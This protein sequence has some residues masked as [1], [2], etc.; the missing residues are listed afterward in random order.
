MKNMAGAP[1]LVAA[2]FLAL[3]FC[4]AALRTDA[5]THVAQVAPT[6][7]RDFGSPPSGRYPIL[8]NNHTVYARPDILKRNR[9]LAALVRDG[10]IYVPLRSMFEQMGAVV[11]ASAD[12]R[13]ITAV[14]PG[15]SVSVTL[16][17]RLV[18]INGESRPLDVP[19]ML[20]KGV[21]LV[22]VRVLSE[23]LGAYVKWVPRRHIVVVRY[24]PATPIATPTP[25][26][27]V[28]P[29]A[30]PT[31]VP[32]AVPIVIP[33]RTYRGFIEAAVAKGNDYNEFS[34][35]QYCRSYLASGA[36][37]FEH[38]KFAVKFGYRYDT[39]VTSDNLTDAYGNHYTQFATID[40]GSA[41]TPVFLA[42]QSTLDARL[43]YQVAAPR[44]YV[45]VGYLRATNNYGY[46]TLNGL[47]VGVEKLPDLRRG[48]NFFG[49]AFYY[50]NASGNYTVTSSTSP[51][52]GKVYRQQYR[53]LQYNVGL[54]LVFAHSPV[55]IYGGFS[56]DRYGAEQNAPIGQT[57]G[58]PYIGL[59]LKF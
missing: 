33:L 18:V 12:G 50:P 34:A 19:P 16:G 57:H 10:R 48:I 39:Y 44:V 27:T 17:K 7:A 4:G 32:T 20:Y 23:A 41:F 52:A 22:P 54:D 30:A 2:S 28:A 8:Y 59:G 45:G 47:G 46:P 26:P 1:R 5:A 15:V 9:V 40:G 29:T 24:I 49:S 37:M 56:G 11:T 51:N 53:I 21:M 6:P 25:M 38:S 55:Y 3:A 42:R 13:T 43:E 35:G 14:K 36:Y 58:G 31:A